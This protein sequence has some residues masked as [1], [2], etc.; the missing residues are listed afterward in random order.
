MLICYGQRE[1]FSLEYG[2]CAAAAVVIL[3][4]GAVSSGPDLAVVLGLIPDLRRPVPTE[5]LSVE[6]GVAGTDLGVPAGVQSYLNYPVV[7]SCVYTGTY[8]KINKA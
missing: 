5:G 1:V 8:S 4:G 7:F 6:R 3:A 2:D